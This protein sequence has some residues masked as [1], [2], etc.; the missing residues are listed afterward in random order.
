MTKTRVLLFAVLLTLAVSGPSVAHPDH[1]KKVLGVVTMADAVHLMVKTADGKEQTI[2]LNAQTKLRQGKTAVKADA[3][4]V[5]SRVV[6][7]LT[8]KEPPTA[9][10]IE[11]G[12]AAP[13]TKKR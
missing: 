3:L 11:I 10:T 9:A 8:A 2:A 4:K 12:A 7:T 6:I 13:A 1:S 5:G